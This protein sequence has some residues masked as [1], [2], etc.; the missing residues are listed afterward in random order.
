[1]INWLHTVW[2]D[3]LEGKLSSNRDLSFG[4]DSDILPARVVPGERS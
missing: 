2:H 4:F 3:C 1:M